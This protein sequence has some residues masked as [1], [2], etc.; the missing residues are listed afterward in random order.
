MGVDYRAGIAYGWEFSGKEHADFIKATGDKY[1]DCFIILDPY[2]GDSATQKAIFGVWLKTNPC[3][4]TAVSYL[5]FNELDKSFNL[6]EW[7][8]AF[9]EAGYDVSKLPA[10]K[11]FLVN[12]VY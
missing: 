7:I 8:K 2:Y 5:N 6:T 1:E 12:Q 10:P 9:E 4:G 11:H 3:I